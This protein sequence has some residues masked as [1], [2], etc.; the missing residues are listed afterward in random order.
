MKNDFLR[1]TE[2]KN[3][4]TFLIL[5]NIGTVINN[6]ISSIQRGSVRDAENAAEQLARSRVGVQFHLTNSNND[7]NEVYPSNN[8]AA[9]AST[10]ALQF[11]LLISIF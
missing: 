10:N 4:L 2:L 9:S 5:A 8:A 3:S 11:V 7:P 1:I 6:L